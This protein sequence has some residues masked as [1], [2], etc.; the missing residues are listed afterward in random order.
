MVPNFLRFIV[1]FV[2]VK[3]NILYTGVSVWR[4]GKIFVFRNWFLLIIPAK[5]LHNNDIVLVHF[6]HYYCTVICDKLNMDLAML[7]NIYLDVYEN[8]Y[9]PAKA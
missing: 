1:E 9:V 2:C 5:P 8:I 3:Y 4:F 7:T 6:N